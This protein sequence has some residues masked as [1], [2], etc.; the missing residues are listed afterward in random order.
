MI[1]ADFN[2]D[3]KSSEYQDMISE[4]KYVFSPRQKIG[5]NESQFHGAVSVF[6]H[7][8]FHSMIDKRQLKRGELLQLKIH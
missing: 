6:C 4:K 1:T 8:S 7:T 3:V 5:R 2:K